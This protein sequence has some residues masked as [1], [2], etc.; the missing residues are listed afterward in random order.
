MRL[1]IITHN[2]DKHVVETSNISEAVDLLVTMNDK[3]F[4]EDSGTF[5]LRKYTVEELV[6]VKAIIKAPNNRMLF[7][8][9]E[10]YS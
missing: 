5:K 7:Y 2:N 3:E 8:L 9:E 10:K 6:D 1:Y 4:Q